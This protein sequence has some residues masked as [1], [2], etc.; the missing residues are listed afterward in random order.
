LSAPFQPKEVELTKKED[1]ELTDN[2]KN[3]KT[4][5]NGISIVATG[6]GHKNHK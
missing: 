4:K 2:Y 3:L 1:K 6:L 5:P